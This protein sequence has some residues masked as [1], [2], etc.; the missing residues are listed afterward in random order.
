M[1]KGSENPVNAAKETKINMVFATNTDISNALGTTMIQIQKFITS[2][3]F[4]SQVLKAGRRT[5]NLRKAKLMNKRLHSP[6]YIQIL[7]AT[8]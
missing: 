5:K 7:R 8:G 4:S 6:Q 2:T 1:V 3:C